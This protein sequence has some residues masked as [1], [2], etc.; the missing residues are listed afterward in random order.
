M[1]HLWQENAYLRGCLN[2]SLRRVG[3][4]EGQLQQLHAQPGMTIR[5]SPLQAGSLKGALLEQE[6]WPALHR[7]GV[8]YYISE[9]TSPLARDFTASIRRCTPQ[10]PIVQWRVGSRDK[11]QTPM[12]VDQSRSGVRPRP[13]KIEA[14]S[15]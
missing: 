10:H 13:C 6:V 12:L 15:R 4:L 3:S 8:Q 1:E 5:T 14:R 7:T 2:S 9:N 11:L